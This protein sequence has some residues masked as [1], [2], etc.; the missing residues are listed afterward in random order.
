MKVCNICK[1]EK[2]LDAYNKNKSR[3]DG[4]EYHCRYCG[5]SK[6]KSYYQRN[7]NKVTAK[8]RQRQ[9][10]NPKLVQE[11]KRKYFQRNRDLVLS[12]QKFE[13]DNL[14]DSYIKKS[15]K[16]YMNIDNAPQEFIEA[17]RRLLLIQRV[18]RRNYE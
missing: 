5:I 13:I 15:L 6:S 2:L 9:L 7:S 8:T 16:R 18:L 17:K 11:Q 14:T 10:D 1:E 12:K 4:L 3:K